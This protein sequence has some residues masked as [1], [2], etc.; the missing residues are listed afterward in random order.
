[1]AIPLQA[2]FCKTTGRLL[3]AASQKLSVTPIWRCRQKTL[4][5]CASSLPKRKK[6][7]ILL[8]HIFDVIKSKHKASVLLSCVSKKKT[9]EARDGE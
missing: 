2:S 4:R 3:I 8:R 6:T 5:K 1:M 9:L 7:V